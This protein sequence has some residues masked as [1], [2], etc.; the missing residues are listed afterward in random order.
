MHALRSAIDEE[1]KLVLTRRVEALI[2]ECNRQPGPEPAAVQIRR[3]YD[4][5]DRLGLNH[6]QT[7]RLAEIVI[8]KFGGFPQGPLPKPAMKVLYSR[9]IAIERRLA[10]LESA[11]G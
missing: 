11:E 6:H 3:A 5:A 7:L 1:S 9:Q 2:K 4:W 8:N 10:L